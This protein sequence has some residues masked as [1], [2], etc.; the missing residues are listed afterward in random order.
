MSFLQSITMMKPP[1]V[2]NYNAYGED[3]DLNNGG[4]VDP[5]KNTFDINSNPY[6]YSGYYLDEESG[7][8][9]L[10]ARY[11]SPELMRFISRDTYDLS[12]R[13]AYGDG[14][15][16]SK[17]DRNGHM[18]QWVGGVVGAAVGLLLGFLIPGAGSI[19]GAMAGGALSSAGATLVGEAVNGEEISLKQIGI[20]AGLGA[21]TGL[22]FGAIGWGCLENESSQTGRPTRA[23]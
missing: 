20:S 7:M 12:N 22:V 6:K 16:I 10:Q 2:Y 5:V 13:Y 17:V 23:I 9:Y 3:T 11:Y 1:M 19:L 21:A 15:P 4:S 14:D 8:Y 18:P